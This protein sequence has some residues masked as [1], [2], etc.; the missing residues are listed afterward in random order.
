MLQSLA[1]DNDLVIAV[2]F[3][4]EDSIKKIAAANPDTNFSG[5][6]ILQGENAPE[7]FASLVFNEAEGSFLV[8]VAA[9]LITG[10]RKVGFIGGG[11]GTPDR[12][13]YSLKA[14]FAKFKR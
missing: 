13:I 14:T 6:D 5:I 8:G 10:T 3:S 1:D 11:C 2:G 7:N 9:A 12:L 4:F